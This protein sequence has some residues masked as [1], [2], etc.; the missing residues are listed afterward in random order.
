MVGKQNDFVAR[1]SDYVL[2]DHGNDQL[3]NL[4]CIIHQEALCSK[5]VDLDNILKDVN[6]IILFIRVNVLHRRQVIQ[7]KFIS[8]NDSPAEDILHHSSVRWL[9]Q[10]E[11]SRRV[12]L[13]RKEILEF[14]ATKNKD[15]PLQ[16][17]A[18]LTS[19]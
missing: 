17:Q 19:L 18:F 7:I 15:C 5:S 3:I 8:T 1:F 11:T 2:K 6:R 13:L 9:S 12:L 14:Y 4:H 10:G 16:N